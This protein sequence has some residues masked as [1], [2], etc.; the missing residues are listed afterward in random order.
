MKIFRIMDEYSASSVGTLLYYEKSKTFIIELETHLDEWTAPLLLTAF[1]RKGIY[2][3]PRDMSFLWVKE[4]VIPSS[5]QNIGAILA[6]HKLKEYDEMKLLELS[7]GK[8]SQDEMYIQKLDRLP[9]Y[10][11]ERQQKNLTECF[12]SENGCAICFFVD[13]TTRKTELSKLTGVSNLDRV[14]K[15]RELL[16]SGKPGPGGYSLTFDDACDIPAT[17]LY[18]YGETI[19]FSLQDLTAFLSRNVYDTTESCRELECSRQNISYLI[20]QGSLT[21]VKEDVKGTLF[22]KGEVLKT[23]W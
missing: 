12:V 6:N 4:R 16:L 10:V 5:R 3:I 1:V 13:G 19:P 20:R 17:D 11:A 18:A 2:T 15:Y 23:K 22:L 14:L 9:D 8:C 7:E 21:P